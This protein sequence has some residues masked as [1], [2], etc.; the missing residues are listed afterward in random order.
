V[1]RLLLEP[2]D[3]STSGRVFLS[4]EDRRALHLLDVL[5]I[6]PGESI[7]VALLNRGRAKAQFLEKLVDGLVFQLQPVDDETP[8]PSGFSLIM[9]LPRPQTL[10]KVLFLAP[11]MGIDRIALIRSRRVEKSFYHSPLLKSGEW[12]RH[13]HLGMEQAGTFRR[14]LVELHERFLPFVEDRLSHW[15]APGSIK[16]IP[17]PG[18]TMAMSDLN[19]P[20]A[21]NVCLA[22]GPEGGWQDHEIDVFMKQEFS[23]VNL[24]ERILRVETAVCVCAA[25]LDLLRGLGQK[26]QKTR[27]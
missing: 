14:P 16:L 24:G 4:I 22:I 1:N 12:R 8:S 23:Q 5:N 2:G 3:C 27:I 19:L 17:H 13:L 21:E 7:Q 9:A 10:R 20:V 11:Q 6:Q 25:Q 15:L 18:T 26:K